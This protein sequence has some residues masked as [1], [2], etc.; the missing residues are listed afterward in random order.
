MSSFCSRKF[1]TAD[2][3]YVFVAFPWSTRTA[4]DSVMFGMD[5]NMAVT[6]C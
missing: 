6:C 2:W 4:S 3:S 1:M 5:P